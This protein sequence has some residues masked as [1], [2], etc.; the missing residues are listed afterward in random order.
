MKRWRR[1]LAN[2]HGFTLIELLVVVI[3][4]GLLVGLVGPRLFGRVGQAKQAAA[5]AQIE[6]IGAGLDQ[7]RLDVGSYPNTS[8]GS[9]PC[10]RTPAARTGTAR[11]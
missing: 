7:Y 2:Q 1:L 11:T 9:T 4:L 5:K 10:R 3:V 8:Q 6:L